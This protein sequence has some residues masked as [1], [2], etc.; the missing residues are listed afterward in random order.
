MLIGKGESTNPGFWN[1]DLMLRGLPGCISAPSAICT[2]SSGDAERI[3][4]LYIFLKPHKTLECLQHISKCLIFS[5][6]FI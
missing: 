1:Y 3:E 6:F 5:N 2:F 4:T